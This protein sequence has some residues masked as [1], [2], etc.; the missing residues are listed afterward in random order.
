MTLDPTIVIVIGSCLVI[1]LIWF[2]TSRKPAA[3]P[4]FEEL[5]ARYGVDEDAVADV[6][7]EFRV[8]GWKRKGRWPPWYQDY[9]KVAID[10]DFF[11]TD[12]LCAIYRTIPAIRIPLRDLTFVETKFFWTTLYR[13]DVFNIRGIPAGQI[14]LPEGYFAEHQRLFEL[15]SDP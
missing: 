2:C 7:L 11:Y 6:P 4:V 10:K 9:I 3:D 8:V 13:L 12:A 5:N 14:L 1:A 15:R